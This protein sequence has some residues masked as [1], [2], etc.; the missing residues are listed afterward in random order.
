MKK[1]F[2]LFICLC[3]TFAVGCVDGDKDDK[4]GNDDGVLDSMPDMDLSDII[5]P[6]VE[7]GK[8]DGEEDAENGGNVDSSKSRNGRGFFDDNGDTDRRIDDIPDTLPDDNAD[9]SNGNNTAVTDG[10]I[11]DGGTPGSPDYLP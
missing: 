7:N 10:G 9:Y 3:L 6:D 5:D 8:I 4:G 2:A 1:I 11:M